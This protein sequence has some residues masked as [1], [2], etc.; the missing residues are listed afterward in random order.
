MATNVRSARTL[1]TPLLPDP[2]TGKFPPGNELRNVIILSLAF[3]TLFCAYNALQNY[4][5]SV[6]PGHLGDESLLVVYCSLSV[7]VF[8]AP[9]LVARL[10][11]TRAMVLGGVTYVIYTLTLMQPNNAIVLA[12]SGV[13]G[14]GAALLWVAQGIYLTKCSP[15]DR[16]GE[17]AGMFW[18]IFYCCNIVGNMAA[19]LLLQRLP[20][21]NLF[22][23]FAVFSAAG[24]ALLLQLTPVTSYAKPMPRLSSAASLASARSRSAS[25]SRIQVT[26]ASPPPV[27]TGGGRGDLFVHVGSANDL[28]PC[29]S[30]GSSSCSSYSDDELSSEDFSKHGRDTLILYGLLAPMSF[31]IGF[32]VAF[33]TGEFTKLLPEDTIGLVL[34]FAGIGEVLGAMGLSWLSDRVGKRTPTFVVGSIAYGIGLYFCSV[35]YHA[36]LQHRTPGAKLWGAPVVAYLAGLGFGVGDGVFN[37]HMYTMIGKVFDAD[38]MEAW[39]LYNL[40]QNGGCAVGYAYALLMP[41][42]AAAGESTSLVQVYTQTVLLVTGTIAYGVADIVYDSTPAMHES[43]SQPDLAQ[44][45]V[46]YVPPV[47]IPTPS[48]RMPPLP[49]SPRLPPKPAHS[50]QVVVDPIREQHQRT[51]RTPTTPDTPSH[52]PIVCC[53]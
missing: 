14:A 20:D 28:S 33:W 7:T 42:V 40:L 36:R 35:M 19:Y 45:P 38:D 34:V 50:V 16:R 32:E 5:T 21:S 12:A 4:I 43:P 30:S 17:Y 26:T 27:R 3:F 2:L 1:H 37:S 49:S 44:C 15:A 53:A 13:V 11:E 39:T 6:L 8:A 41:M 10:G 9:S 25:Q 24:V 47:H 46:S 48:A 51:P 22:T 31:L 23:M 52:R 18:G 29:S